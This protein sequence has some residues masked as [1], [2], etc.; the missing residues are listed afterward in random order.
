MTLTPFH[1]AIPVDNLHKARSFYGDL[2]GCPEGRS[3]ENWVDFNLYGHQL[4]CHL[5][6]GSADES[7]N[8]VDGDAVPIPHF[9]VVLTMAQWRELGGK[10]QEANAT[11][12]TEPHIRFEDQVGEQATLFL[13]DPSGN[14]LEFKAFA[15]AAA[16]RSELFRKQPVSDTLQCI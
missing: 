9:G 7:S 5:A 14:V 10:L 16:I 12:I 2:L 4:V 15:D 8:A 13:R 3:A 11:F 6:G 1:I